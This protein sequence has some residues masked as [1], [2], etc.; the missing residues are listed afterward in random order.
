VPSARTNNSQ[1]VDIWRERL[2]AAKN[3][4]SAAVAACHEAAGSDDPLE[5]RSAVLQETAVLNEY[6]R[7]LRLFSDLNRK[8]R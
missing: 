1:P 2:K 3:D 6:L 8:P 5:I 7:L 4:Y